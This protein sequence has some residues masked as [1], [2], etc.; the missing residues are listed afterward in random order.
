MSLVTIFWP[1]VA[2]TSLTLGGIHLLIWWRN[3]DMP[4]RLWF[5]MMTVATT[6][7]A[8]TEL[9][10]MKAATGAEFGSALRWNHLPVWVN[11]FAVTGFLLT[12]LRAGWRWLAGLAI[13]IRTV[14]LVINFLVHPNI[15]FREI[16]G[17]RQ[18]GFLGDQVSLAVG[19]PS[20]LMALAQSGLL[21]LLAFA[22]GVTL[23]VW[24]RGE[25][26]K[27]L[28]VGGSI[29]FFITAGTM[30]AV[31]S[32]WGL[33]DVPAIGSVYF[34]GMIVLTAFDLSLGVQ[35]AGQLSDE[36]GESERRMT[37][38]AEAVNLGLW[39][40]DVPRD[41]IWA[42]R[43]WRD[44]F[45]F[46][47]EERL[48]LDGVFQ[49]LHPDDREEIRQTMAAAVECGERYDVEY[50][51]V[52]PEGGVRW[53][54]SHGRIE[55]DANGRA[56]RMRGVSRDCTERKAAELETLH[57]RQEITHVGRVSMMG[58]LASALAHEI[59]QPLGAILRN[60]EAAELFLRHE[61]P[62]LDEIRAIL[63]DI[64]R[65][66]QRAG[67]VIERM[68][69]LLRRHDLTA[70]PVEVGE[71]FAEVGSLLRGDAAARKVKLELAAPNDLP[72]A[73]GDRIH[74]QQVLLNLIL[75][76]MDALNGAA[77]EGRRVNVVARLAESRMIEIAVS[78]SGHGIPAEKLA[79][80]FE[81]FFTTKPSG[82]GMGL[83]ISQNIVETHGGRLWAENNDAGGGAVFR[84]TLPLID[85]EVMS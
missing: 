13:G 40:R 42:N 33:V 10:M 76:G 85:G 46:A 37:L 12:H 17:V 58:Q 68:R 52:L 24:R 19:Q 62:D 11:F 72:P 75:N 2:A 22:I 53:I 8:F 57:L 71:L 66:D 83:P 38:A 50:R 34:L 81:P 79:H 60:A 14:S 49:R 65:D 29:V 56:L 30:Q 69:T 64:R 9:A 61:S 21:L 47:P 1:M 28:L 36:L 59:N 35:R 20:P 48:E 16:T 44:L 67:M 18:V 32:H 26:R 41:E 78:D 55:A 74:L 5:F 73:L 77:A 63:A 3:R 80:V 27:A 84:F 82:I 54:A 45:G 15:N 51:V 39:I 70:R 4:E 7:M 23:S 43:Q 25:K 6:G 31:L